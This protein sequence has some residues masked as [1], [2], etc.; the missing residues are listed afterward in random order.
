VRAPGAGGGAVLRGQEGG[1][2][3]GGGWVVFLGRCSA[4]QPCRGASLIWRRL[5]R[6]VA[7]AGGAQAPASPGCLGAAAAGARQPQVPQRWWLHALARLQ[8]AGRARRGRCP[9]APARACERADQQPPPQP[10]VIW[11]RAS[12]HLGPGA[13]TRAGAPPASAGAPPASAAAA[14][15]CRRHA[16]HSRLMPGTDVVALITRNP[17]LLFRWAGRCWELSCA[18]SFFCGGGGGGGGGGGPGGGGGR[19]PR[20]PPPP[21][22]PPGAAPAGGG[23]GRPAPPPPFPLHMTSRPLMMPAVCSEA[24]LCSAPA[25][26]SWALSDW[27]RRRR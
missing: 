8:A 1:G 6:M 17:S 26:S 18:S 7:A 24:P 4:G 12:P 5:V 9:A 16:A 23:G 2:W 19:G 27:R 21:P 11:G 14:P 15:T 20:A 22:P 10:V 13:A 3:L 25:P